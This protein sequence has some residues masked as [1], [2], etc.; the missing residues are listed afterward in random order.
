MSK[1]QDRSSVLLLCTI[2]LL[3][4]CTRLLDMGGECPP[5]P[6]SGDS[7]PKLTCIDWVGY[8]GNA[9]RADAAVGFDS[10]SSTNDAAVE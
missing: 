5:A 2:A 6:D 1:G 4:A 8:E 3:A 10:G 7:V 9:S